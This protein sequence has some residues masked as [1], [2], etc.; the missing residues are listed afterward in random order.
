MY[1]R[2]A[3][4]GDSSP[5]W[6]WTSIALGSLKSVLEW[7]QFY[8]ALPQDRL[9]IFSSPSREALNEQFLRENQDLLSASVPAATFLRERCITP[10]GAG[11][12]A[13]GGRT[14]GNERIASIGA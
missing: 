5:T 2:V 10:P 7:L 13:S 4:Q 11:R 14:R 9:H 1:Y 12:E 8:R 3:I 6:Q